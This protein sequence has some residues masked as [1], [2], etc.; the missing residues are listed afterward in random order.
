LVSLQDNTILNTTQAAIVMYQPGPLL[1]VDNRF[2]V[3]NTWPLSMQEAYTSWPT[4]DV[5]AIG[6]TYDSRAPYEHVGGRVRS[7][8]DVAGVPL[9]AIPPPEPPPTPRSLGRLVF[10]PVGGDVQAAITAAVSSG[11]PRAIVH[12]PHGSYWINK[13]I[14]VPPGS[15]V[16]IVGD[17]EARS[18]LHAGADGS[19][20]VVKGPSHVIVRDLSVDGERRAD[21]IRLDNADQAGGQFRADELT[22]KES[23]IGVLAGG[24]TQTMTQFTSLAAAANSG[25]AVS[26]RHGARASILGGAAAANSVGFQ[27]A[28]DSSLTVMDMWYDGGATRQLAPGGSGT[29]TWDGGRLGGSDDSSLD[30]STFD[31]SVNLVNQLATTAVKGGAHTLALGLV[32]TK[33]YW[34]ATDAPWALWSNRTFLA[35]GGSQQAVEQQRGVIDADGYLRAHLASLRSTALAAPDGLASGVT[36]VRI[37]RVGISRAVRGLVVTGWR[38]P[39]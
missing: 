39:R 10:E 25:A 27:V 34:S 18:V 13:T 9:A 31:G 14:E 30:G 8:D 24:L 6:N 20:L 26:A 19:V 3:P 11:S 22:V 7:V 28:E 12:L 23:F 32:A 29:F 16:Q 2:N 35:S 36:D 21:G 15:D 17:G 5:A 33:G 4:A 1:L 38:A 37:T